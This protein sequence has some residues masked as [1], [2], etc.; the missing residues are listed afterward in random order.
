M[1]S[2]RFCR[3]LAVF[4]LVL[5]PVAA[6]TADTNT[7]TI[8][9]NGSSSANLVGA[10]HLTSA[11]SVSARISINIDSAGAQVPSSGNAPGVFNQLTVTQDTATTASVLLGIDP[12]ILGALFRLGGNTYTGALKI[13]ATGCNE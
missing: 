12:T 1:D 3:F 4:L 2:F 9:Y 7:I 6:Q 13:S 10:V 11:S 8:S 5:I